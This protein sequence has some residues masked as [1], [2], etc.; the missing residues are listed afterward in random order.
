MSEKDAIVRVEHNVYYIDPLRLGSHSVS[1]IYLL[2]GEDV[3]LIETGTSHV[4]PHVFEAVRAI[5][6]KEKDIAR[7]IVTHVHLDHAGA[8]GWLVRR[9]PHVR[10]YVHERGARHLA[11]PSR[12]MESAQMVYGDTETIREIHGEILPV[13]EGNLVPVKDIEID[14]GSGIRLRIFDA[15]GHAPHHVCIFEP[16]TGILFAG[17]ALGHYIPDFDVLTPAV[18]P[19]G[20][21]LE[22]SVETARKIR[23][24]DPRIICFSQF[25]QHRDPAFILEESERQTRNYG[26]L[27]RIS[28]ENGLGTGDI[29]EMMLERLSREPQARRFSE[30]SLRGMLMSIVLGYYQY[31]RRTGAIN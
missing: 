31:F 3:T 17:E 27:I 19:P 4:A 10:V 12:L 2:V 26:E 20:F 11:D 24:L 18:A 29:I 13:P 23:G 28:L 22:A 14:I 8:T 9:V 7:C 15:P 1:G 21:D 16:G 25:G 5:G 6:L 30:Q